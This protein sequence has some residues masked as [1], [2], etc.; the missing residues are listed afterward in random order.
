MTHPENDS[1]AFDLTIPFDAVRSLIRRYAEDTDTPV[2][3]DAVTGA[4]ISIMVSWGMASA[5]L[6]EMAASTGRV[7]GEWFPLGAPLDQVLAGLDS[8]TAQPG[9][10]PWPESV[11]TAAKHIVADYVSSPRLHD[12][13]IDRI[14]ALAGP[15]DQQALLDAGVM[16]CLELLRSGSQL[17]DAGTRSHR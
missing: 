16:M 3:L 15:S 11:L 14:E 13:P 1:A 4:Q 6:A 5:I 17:R 12:S 2:T 9:W 10:S 8:T 7:L